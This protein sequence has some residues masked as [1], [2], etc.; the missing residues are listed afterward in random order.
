VEL[1]GRLIR[2]LYEDPDLMQKTG[3]TYIAVELAEQ[4]GIRDIDGNL[5]RSLRDERGP[6]IWGPV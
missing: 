3:A 6:P 5:P 1:P 4:Y 2:A